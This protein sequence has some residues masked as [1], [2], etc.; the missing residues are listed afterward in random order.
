[1][2]DPNARVLEKLNA[3]AKEK[4]QTAVKRYQEYKDLEESEV[5]VTIEHW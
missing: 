5:L 4:Q 2:F 1:M 3:D